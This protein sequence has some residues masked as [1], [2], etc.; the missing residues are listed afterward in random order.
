ML[1]KTNTPKYSPPKELN[2]DYKDFRGGWNNLFKP[3]EVR[4]NELVQ[5]DNLVLTGSGVPTKRWGSRNYFLASPT[6]YGRG[7]V[8][9]KSANATSELLVLTDWGYLT[10]KS[11]SSYTQLTGASWPSGY[12]LEGTQ[13]NDN[14]YLVSQAREMVRYNFNTL[15]AFV[16]L[17]APTGTTATNLSGASGTYNWSW[18][19]TAV[20]R[21]G[22]TLGSVPI[23][24]ASMP[25][26]L[27]TSLVRV[28]W[29]P[30]SAA[31]GILVGYNIYRGAPGDEVWVGGVDDLTTRFDDYGQSG[32]I[33]RMPPTA[34]TTGGP[35][36]K[37]ISRYQDRL[38]IGGIAGTP[39]TVFI[40]GRV[41]N[42]ERFD[43]TAGGGY[44]NV[45]PA[46]GDDVTGLGVHQGRIIAF[47]ENSV[48]QVTLS[49]TTIGNYSVLEP[50]YQLITA[51]QGCTS[52]RSI[53]A[54]DNDLLFLGRKGVYV[55]GYEPNI[56][57]DVLRT[58]ELSAKIRPFFATLSYNDLH[59][60]TA[61]YFD[62]KYILAFPEARK[63]I[64][65]DKERLAWMGP[66]STTFGINKF[67]KY[68]DEQ[69]IERLL[70]ADSDDGYVS[71]FS[72]VLSDDK[73]TAFG[74]VLKTKKDDMGD[75]TIFKTINEALIGFRNIAGSVGTNIYIEDRSGTNTTAKSFTSVGPTMQ[76]TAAWGN[77]MWGSTEWGDTGNSVSSYA[78]ETIKRALLYKTARYIQFEITTTGR[79]DNYE[80]LGIKARAIPQGQGSVPSSWNVD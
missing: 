6:G 10:K 42:H 75:F 79:S 18:R 58:N 15:T 71:E 46:T 70:C 47:K 65:F 63:V 48:W 12:N 26:Q 37:F 24:L 69:G 50:N 17:S 77:D 57:G 19:I 2:L 33:L 20:S 9:A 1:T 44:V 22:E 64:I 38:I 25:Q 54:V 68:V 8:W 80:L 61:T 35:K 66:W 76:I 62:Y 67:I 53:M 59:N 23:S 14:V 11:G 31:S 41:P 72:N 55:L 56:T 36:A 34:D 21:V 16:T 28:N 3:T 49:S 32:T 39:T 30:V 29:S 5:A 7:L 51:S 52:H 78:E 27:S 4:Q 45:D 43:W 73:G 40:S 60:A 74:T 13:L